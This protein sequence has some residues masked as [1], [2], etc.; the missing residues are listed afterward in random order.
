MI[1]WILLSLTNINGQIFSEGK[2]QVDSTKIKYK[3]SFWGEG[4]AG[5]AYG[6]IGITGCASVEILQNV[7]LSYEYDGSFDF[8]YVIGEPN[9]TDTES[10]GFTLGYLGK[11]GQKLFYLTA[12]GTRIRGV[13][14]ENQTENPYE[15]Y[16]VKLRVGMLYTWEYVA[17][18]ITPYVNVN[19]DLF[20]GGISANLAFGRFIERKD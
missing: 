4:G 16:R 11:F 7:I 8:N 12:G 9:E 19:S 14:R 6:R 10:R 17:I 13:K 5:T 2:L 3:R 15:I 20:Y 18:G 1:A